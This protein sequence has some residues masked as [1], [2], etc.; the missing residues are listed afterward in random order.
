MTLGSQVLPFA[1]VAIGLVLLVMMADGWIGQI[2]N[3]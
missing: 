1:L 2:I 3:R